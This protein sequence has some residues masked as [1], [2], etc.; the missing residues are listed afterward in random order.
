M[1]E[2]PAAILLKFFS[3]VMTTSY[4]RGSYRKL[5]RSIKLFSLQKVFDASSF[6][7]SITSWIW[8]KYG[9]KCS[10]KWSILPESKPPKK[11]PNKGQRRVF[12][13][14]WTR[15]KKTEMNKREWLVFNWQQWWCATK[16]LISNA[17]HFDN[18]VADVQLVERK[19]G[20]SSRSKSTQFP[21]ISR[22]HL[23]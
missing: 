1:Q 3:K 15:Y 9:G 13:S 8:C 4:L 16:N 18:H 7:G 14:F 11:L 10:F 22:F 20:T 5:C 12:T 17:L 2:R 23:E 6:W 21:L 19:N